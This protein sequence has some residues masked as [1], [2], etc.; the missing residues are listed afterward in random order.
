MEQVYITEKTKLLDNNGNVFKPGYCK[1]NRYVYERSAIKARKG[2]IKEWDYYQIS[3]DTHTVHFNIFDVSFVGSFCFSVFNRETGERLE[4]IGA[5]LFTDG[6]V[7]LEENTN[8][9]HIVTFDDGVVYAKIIYSNGQRKLYARFDKNKIKYE[10]EFVLE[11]P[12][13]LQSLV[14]AVP[15]KKDKYFYHNQ[16]TNSMIASGYI[17]ADGEIIKEFKR[18][19]SFAVLDW[20][21]GVWPYAT[22]WYW[23]NGN[24]HLPDGHVFGF[25]IGWGFGNMSYAT[26][27]M[28]FYDGVAHK[29]EEVYL[30]RDEKDFMK[31]WVFT[32]NDGRFEMTM[33][34]TYDN[35]TSSRLAIIGNICHQVFGKWNGTATLDD[36]TVL[37]IKDMLA[38]CEFSDY[39]W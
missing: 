1:Y 31:P 23:G 6:A 35:F 17:K 12:P 36:G 28:L 2:R 26:E 30:K 8:K 13:E 32:S 3:D 34:P 14:L 21:R 5:T 37:E 9:P 15:F 4:K 22:K 27:N 33:T 18:D 29:I 38:F 25:E 24:C 20:G 11:C 7:G 39:L 16:K 19:N 10:V